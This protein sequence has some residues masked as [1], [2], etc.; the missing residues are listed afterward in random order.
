MMLSTTHL[1]V[2]AAT[3][4]LIPNPYI[5][6]P[7]AF[8][9]HFLLDLIPHWNWKPNTAFKMAAAIVEGMFG[10]ILVFILIKH[11]NQPLTVLTASIISVIP[12]AIQGPHYLW[13]SEN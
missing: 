7:I 12:D 1:I 10:L 6:F 4:T 2:G 13:G 5:A 3:A 11:S 9:S 8:F